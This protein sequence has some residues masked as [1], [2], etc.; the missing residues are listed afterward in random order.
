[1]RVTTEPKQIVHAASQNQAEK[2]RRRAAF[3]ARL[4]RGF[5][6]LFLAIC[7]ATSYASETITYYHW[8]ALG[9]PVAA[10]DAAGNVVWREQ[11]RPYGE[12]IRNESAASTNT[13]WYTGHSQDSE[14][15]LVYAGARYYDP[16]IGRFMAVDPKSFDENNRHSFN[17]YKYGN[18]NPYLY[19]D[20]NGQAETLV[21][22]FGGPLPCVV[23]VGLTV[24]TAYYGI[25]AVQGTAQALHSQSSNDSG[26]GSGDT[27]PPAAAP[28]N[29][30]SVSPSPGNNDGGDN[31]NKNV[32][33]TLQRG[34]RTISNNTTRELNKTSGQN[35]TRRDWGRALENLKRENGLRGDDH[36]VLKA[37]GSFI[38]SRGVYRGNI[39]DYIP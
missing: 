35:L 28:S 27:A 38:D 6:G 16:V 33:R 30:D 36:G 25:K 34:D 8:D 12:R 2:R 11:Y 13:R 26:S 7:T 19:T 18:D 5:V 22:C 21:L 14:T 15:G 9:S 17:R 4:L 3:I 10:T 1:M 29:S 23:G 39:I 31:N 24:A 32:S 20:P 37:D